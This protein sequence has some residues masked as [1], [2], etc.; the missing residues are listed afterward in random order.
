M[1]PV[2]FMSYANGKLLG[3]MSIV[4]PHSFVFILLASMQFNAD[5]LHAEPALDT[6]KLSGQILLDNSS[7]TELVISNIDSDEGLEAPTNAQQTPATPSRWKTGT[8]PYQAEV[9][10]VA[11][12]TQIDPAL[13]H[14]V[15]ATESG[16]NPRAQSSK[17][18]YGLM[19]VLPSTARDLTSVPIKQ[20]SAKQ[21][22]LWGSRYLKTMLD[23]FEGNVSLALAA[24]NAGPQAVKAHHHTLPPFAETRQYVPK[25]LG[26]YHAFKARLPGERLAA[27]Q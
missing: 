14:A 15:I 18:A 26:Y 16:Y 2:F 24:Y 20:W 7:E 4:K 3:I 5:I 17:G 12:A 19:Q 6:L 10:A 23:M 25:V 9:E 22:I 1:L 8:I 27:N 13:I 11:I 21:Q